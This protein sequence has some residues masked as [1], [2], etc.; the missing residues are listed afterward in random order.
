M[1]DPFISVAE[2]AAR[3]AGRFLRTAFSQSRQITQKAPND[4][5]TDA[6]RGAERVIL[7]C[8]RDHFP[9]HEI[10][11]EETGTHPGTAG[12]TWIVDPL[13]GTTNYA[14]A[15]PCFC[16]SI[17]VREGES[18]LAGVVY[19]PL[20]DELFSARR[21]AGASL[22]GAPIRASATRELGMALVATGF[23]YDLTGD[24]RRSLAQ[25]VAVA[26][27]AQGIRRAGSAALDLCAVACGR[28]DAYWE[29]GIAPWD[30]AA[31]VLIVQEGGGLVTGL[32]GEPFVLEGRAVLAS[33]GLVH[34]ELIDALAG[35]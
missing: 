30:I 35:A 23:P 32:A 17:A 4:L 9:G 10:L 22:N 6:D 8:I 15:Y 12:I 25:L 18:L 11:S 13:D 28:L 20:R 2:E 26:P 3:A 24:G 19:D 16:V 33:N 34:S 21:G 27:R 31:G 7:A 14:H 1:T 29:I 5:V